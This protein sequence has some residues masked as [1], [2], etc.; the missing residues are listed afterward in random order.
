MRASHLPIHKIKP[1]LIVCSQL[2]TNEEWRPLSAF[3]KIYYMKG[4][5]LKRND[6]LRAGIQNCVLVVLHSL[7]KGKGLSELVYLDSTIIMA[8]HQIDFMA[9]D[10]RK[11]GL[12]LY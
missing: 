6:L 3:P 9:P 11:D 1:I 7:K 10:K 4:T 2:P 8:S 12:N 5:P